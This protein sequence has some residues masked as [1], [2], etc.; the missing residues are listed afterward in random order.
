MPV[1]EST[2]SAKADYGSNRTDSPKKAFTRTSN[3][4]NWP[5]SGKRKT[6]VPPLQLSKQNPQDDNTPAQNNGF[7]RSANEGDNSGP[8]KKVSFMGSQ[9]TTGQRSYFSP[10]SAS[11]STPR[12]TPT[13]NKKKFRSNLEL[14]ELEYR[15]SNA[16]PVVLTEATIHEHEQIKDMEPLFDYSVELR[17]LRVNSFQMSKGVRNP[18]NYFL[19]A[20]QARSQG[21]LKAALSLY[22]K[23]LHLKPKDFKSAFNRGYV[24]DRL[25]YLEEARADYSYAAILEP[26]SSFTLFNGGIVEARQRKLDI[27][28]ES[29]TRAIDIQYRDVTAL[30][31]T[32]SFM[33]SKAD[34][35]EM[36]EYEMKERTSAAALAVFLRIRGLVRR[37]NSQFS[38]ASRDYLEANKILNPAMEEEET[39]RRK[40]RKQQNE[41][42][43][44]EL[45]E[46]ARRRIM[47]RGNL[48]D[49]LSDFSFE[50]DGTSRTLS[51]TVN[52]EAKA[53]NA[54]YVQIWGNRQMGMLLRDCLVKDAYDKYEDALE[55]HKAMMMRLSAEDQDNAPREPELVDFLDQNAFVNHAQDAAA[56]AYSI[57]KSLFQSEVGTTSDR[58]VVKGA[59]VGHGDTTAGRKGH[60][61]KEYR[62]GLEPSEQHD[63]VGEEGQ[64][65]TRAYRGTKGKTLMQPYCFSDG[66]VYDP[67]NFRPTKNASY[68]SS[69]KQRFSEIFPV[70]K[71]RNN[72]TSVRADQATR[73]SLSPILRRDVDLLTRLTDNIRLFYN[74]AQ[75]V[76]QSMVTRLYWTE[77]PERS[78]ICNEGEWG[79]C[80][81]VVVEG[82]VDF[83]LRR[84]MT[85]GRKIKQTFAVF[86]V[87]KF[88]LKWVHRYRQKKKEKKLKGDDEA[89][90]GDAPPRIT[91]GHLKGILLSLGD[92]SPYPIRGKDA[93]KAVYGD[94]ERKFGI[95]IGSVYSGEGFGQ[96]TVTGPLQRVWSEE[97]NGGEGDYVDV[98]F[99]PVTA[100]AREP[101][102]LLALRRADYHYVMKCHH[103]VILAEQAAWLSKL[104]LLASASHDEISNLAQRIQHRRFR[105]GEV[106]LSQDCPVEGLYML[107]SGKCV[108]L[109]SRASPP[110]GTHSPTEEKE[111]DNV[112]ARM[113]RRASMS[114]WIDV[115]EK[116]P[117]SDGLSRVTSVAAEAAK[118]KAQYHD[119]ISLK[120]VGESTAQS[121][122]FSNVQIGSEMKLQ[123][124]LSATQPEANP[125]SQPQPPSSNNKKAT[126]SVTRKQR[127]V[128]QTNPMI[129]SAWNPSSTS[130]NGIQYLGELF[131]RDW[132]GEAYVLTAQ[133][134]TAN[135]ATN[136]YVQCIEDPSSQELGTSQA[137]IIAE[138]DGEV[139]L[140]KRQDIF[141]CCSFQTRQRM[142]EFL[143]S[144]VNSSKIFTPKQQK[145]WTEY[146]KIVLDE[147]VL[148]KKS[149]TARF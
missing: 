130:G 33:G 109:R 137:T 123:R 16:L 124:R 36:E 103:E 112:A 53:Q 147:E 87:G 22:T 86:K 69:L 142:R 10:T 84:D 71:I 82:S 75:R 113:F 125:P 134:T 26:K 59:A 11:G 127:Q 49:R 64:T 15:A 44:T 133:M 141:E 132:F 104:H 60:V 56:N 118:P 139:W 80:L 12:T 25:G 66:P 18:D 74:Q 92:R 149:A 38:E 65:S 114:G 88:L 19:R 79:D 78:A 98:R 70:L 140:L 23:A 94:T 122:R 77:L 51:T 42:H 47:A 58:T 32:M 50:G 62:A 126:A 90:E 110:K 40:K 28:I 34:P 45:L 145:V 105:C 2:N 67:G 117:R 76:Q 29:L 63:T 35:E 146:K 52:P 97:A 68:P 93:E 83:Y 48:A 116:F 9:M 107:R 43:K 5:G 96:D 54:E 120:Q 128:D 102:L 3:Q 99:R 72:G 111:K 7:S 17:P 138:T 14:E 8:T 100:V 121:R 37:R 115:N 46:A 129:R 41:Q 91:A 30:R 85:T 1:G 81:Y 144:M 131:P 6:P 61:V 13:P 101:C 89:T 143:E 24:Y 136:S 106:I 4:S 95:H 108:V 20:F 73:D 27:A 57:W 148:K 135:A 39:E 119:D 31:Q 55:D 21:K